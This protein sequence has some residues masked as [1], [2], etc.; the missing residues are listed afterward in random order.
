MSL[1]IWLPMFQDH[2]AVSNCRKPN[3]RWC[4]T[5]SQKNGHCKNV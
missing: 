2:L 5:I 3:T 4:R 1:S